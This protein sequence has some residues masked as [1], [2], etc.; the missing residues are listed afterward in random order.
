MNTAPQFQVVN[1]LTRTIEEG[2]EIIAQLQAV[3][4]LLEEAIQL[5]REMHSRYRDAMENYEVGETEELAEAVIMAQS[6]EGPLG[7][8]ATTSKAYDICLTNLKNELRGGKLAHSWQTVER[9]RRGYE[10]AQVE[11]EQTQTRFNALRKIADLKT[12]V[13]RASTI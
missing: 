2:E 11:L 7:G 13:L 12:Q 6:K 1:P 3:S 4:A 8:I 10:L 5:E 9:H